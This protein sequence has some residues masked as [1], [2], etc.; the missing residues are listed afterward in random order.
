MLICGVNISYLGR[1]SQNLF[2]PRQRRVILIVQFSKSCKKRKKKGPQYNSETQIP[3]P[4]ATPSDGIEPKIDQGT[5]AE[6]KAEIN[7]TT[8]KQES[9][10]VAS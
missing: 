1:Y 8:R 7:I 6:E 2:C 4:S 9:I 10:L 5:S 3:L